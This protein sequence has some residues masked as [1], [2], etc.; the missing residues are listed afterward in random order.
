[1]VMCGGRLSKKTCLGSDAIDSLLLIGQ[2][3]CVLGVHWLVS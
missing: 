3:L 2:T 1:M